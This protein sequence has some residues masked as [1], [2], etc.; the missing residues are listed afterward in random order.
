MTDRQHEVFQPLAL[1]DAAGCLTQS[2]WARFPYWQFDAGAVRRAPGNLRQWDFFTVMDDRAAL[3]LTMAN[4]CFGGL[5]SAE[6]LDLRNKKLQVNLRPFKNTAPLSL[7]EQAGE[8]ARWRGKGVDVVDFVRDGSGM[9]LRFHLAARAFFPRMH[10]DVRLIWPR[11]H[12]SLACVFPFREQRGGFFYENKAP[13]IAAE[14]TV[15]AGHK[16]FDF[17]SGS[18]FAVMD[19]GRGVWPSKVFWRWASVSARVDGR[20][21]GVNL[22]NGF[23]DTAEGSENIV[24]V[25]GRAHKLGEVAWHLDRED[26][27]K[28]WR[29]LAPD[30]RF[31]M[32]FEPTFDQR[33]NLNLWIKG[34][35]AHRVWGRF[36]G[37]ARLDDGRTL[38]LPPSMGFAEEVWIRW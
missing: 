18:A 34:I 17:S 14:G 7:S 35:R 25:D 8:S 21:I 36:S 27:M 11:E 19:W 9:T 24:I 13:G 37:Q 26:Y 10:G 4:L 12:Q 38:A 2:G 5:V 28:P 30:G 22:G 6:L 29:M 1:L 15:V 33:T 32:T 23:G 31:E 20:I 16:R 3:S